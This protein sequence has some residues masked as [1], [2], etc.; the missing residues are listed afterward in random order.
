MNENYQVIRIVTS[1]KTYYFGLPRG[2]DWDY[3]TGY[4]AALGYGKEESIETKE[5]KQ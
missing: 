2:R 5:G 4:I 3:W 1:Q